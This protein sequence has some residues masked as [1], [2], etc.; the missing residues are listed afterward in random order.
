M[1]HSYH[2][3]ARW[4]A[5]VA[6]L[7]LI[8]AAIAGCNGGDSQGMASPPAAAPPPGAGSSVP[9]AALADVPAFIRFIGGL[10]SD[11]TH[12]P[13]AVPGAAPPVSDSDEPQGI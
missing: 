9:A 3:G 13:L 10:A 11:D 8:T 6:P 5:A 12:E 1:N 4:T 7:A 2:T